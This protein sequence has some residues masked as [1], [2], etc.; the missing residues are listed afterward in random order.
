[1]PLQVVVTWPCLRLLGTSVFET[2]A[3]LKFANLQYFPLALFAKFHRVTEEA[4]IAETAV[5]PILFLS[6]KYFLCS[7]R[8]LTF[9]FV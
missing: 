5:W 2:T 7:L 8:V 9:L 6:Y 3:L 1:M 4:L